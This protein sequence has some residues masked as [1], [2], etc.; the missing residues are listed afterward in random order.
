MSKKISLEKLASIPS[1][2]MVEPNKNRD[3]IGFYWNK[4][5]RNEFYILDLNTGKYNQITDGELPKAI[6]A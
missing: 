1:I 4:T 5:K 3:K 2:M 6:R